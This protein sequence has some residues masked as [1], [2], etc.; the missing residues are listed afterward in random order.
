[1]R[2]EQLEY[3][4]AVATHGS[5][6]RASESLHLSQQAL[7]EAISKLE[8][9]LGIRLL[10]RRRSGSRVSP[11]GLDLLDQMGDVLD[12]VDRLRA[13]AGHRAIPRRALRIGTVSA[14]ASTV[15]VPALRDLQRR[16]GDGTFDLRT[17]PHA[18]VQRSVAE[19][20]LDLGLVNMLPGDDLTADVVPHEL[21][22]GRPVVCL[23]ADHPLA[24]HDELTVDRLRGVPL[25]AM[26][27]GFVMSRVA[28]R[29][30]GTHLPSTTYSATGADTGK[31]MVADGLGVTLLPDYSVEGD[32]LVTAG[33][34]THRPVAAP[35]PMVTLLALH[36][37][38]E[39]VPE[40]LRDLLTALLHHAAACADRS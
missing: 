11:P 2:I 34:L 22:R 15:L 3:V 16:Q 7:S 10:D 1:M 18:D 8:K 23:R 29:L 19:G 6:R 36:R 28:R 21:L 20:A 4:A 25:V 13:A 39:R 26:G 38:A 17:L 32:P 33:V 12:A 9:E 27:E 14:A 5:L 24:E 30:F 31:A 40:P 35:T 37:R